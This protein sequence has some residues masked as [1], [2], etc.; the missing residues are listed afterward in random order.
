MPTVPGTHASVAC[1]PTNVPTTVPTIPPKTPPSTALL[2]FD[3]GPNMEPM[4][5]KSSQDLGLE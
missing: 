4:Q 5:L 1:V 3:E 2:S